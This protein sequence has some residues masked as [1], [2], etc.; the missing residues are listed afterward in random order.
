[1]IFV[2]M[3]IV[4]FCDGSHESGHDYCKDD[5]GGEDEDDKEKDG[6]CLLLLPLAMLLPLLLPPQALP[7]RLPHLPLP[8]P[9]SR[10]R[11]SL[12]QDR[13]LRCRQPP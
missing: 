5:V 12:R 1:M 3:T 4:V 9:Q 10:A 13:N 2:V 11:P 6:G 8:S 7:L